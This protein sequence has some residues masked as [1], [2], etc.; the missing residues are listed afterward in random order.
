MG[1]LGLVA[2]PRQ[3]WRPLIAPIVFL[4]AVTLVVA[5][6]RSEL[7]HHSSAPAPV[8]AKVARKAVPKHHGRAVYVVRAGD[9]MTAIAAKT[10]VSLARLAKLNPRIS[11]TALFIGEKIHLR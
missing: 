9:T 1:R 7:R 4:L 5:L 8:R 11:P 10:G 2:A 6:V 3:A